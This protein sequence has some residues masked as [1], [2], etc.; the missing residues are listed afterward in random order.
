MVRVVRVPGTYY[1][2]WCLAPFMQFI[3]SNIQSNVSQIQGRA[4]GFAG[5]ERLVL[6]T[7][8]EMWQGKRSRATPPR[9]PHTRATSSSVWI[10]AIGFISAERLVP[11]TVLEMWQGKR[12]RATFRATPVPR[13]GVAFGI[14]G[15]FVLDEVLEALSGRSFD[16]LAV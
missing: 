13:P 10:W 4:I 15:L 11:G 3:H 9:R 6:G 7:N 1:V 5:V 16:F 2:N 14:I 12:P 8:L